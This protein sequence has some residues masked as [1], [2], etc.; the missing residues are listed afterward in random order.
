MVCVC[1]GTV[2]TVERDFVCTA[3]T[4]EYVSVCA[5]EGERCLWRERM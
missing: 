3:S 5:R 1:K 4:L 2:M